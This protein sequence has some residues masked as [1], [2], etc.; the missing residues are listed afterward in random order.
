MSFPAS[1]PVSTLVIFLSTAVSLLAKPLAAYSYP[2]KSFL[3]QQYVRYIFRGLILPF[4]QTFD[5]VL[6]QRY[7]PGFDVFDLEGR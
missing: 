3:S 2:L 5:R 7:S 4:G 1:Q 6:N